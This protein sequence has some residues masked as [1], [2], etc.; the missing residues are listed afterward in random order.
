MSVYNFIG[1]SAARFWHVLV[2]GMTEYELFYCDCSGGD[3]DMKYSDSLGRSTYKE[4][5]A[6]YYRFDLLCYLLCYSVCIEVNL[7]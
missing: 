7:G 5:Y 1:R 6:Y 2:F 3:W 4:Q